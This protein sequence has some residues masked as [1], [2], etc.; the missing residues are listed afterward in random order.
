MDNEQII[1]ILLLLFHI[2][3]I[4]VEL[5][6][7]SSS[8]IEA[9]F[10]IKY[11]LLRGIAIVSFGAFY[12]LLIQIKGTSIK[13]PDGTVGIMVLLFNNK[14]LHLNEVSIT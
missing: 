7:I 3:F 14:Y 1:I 8:S 10:F 9:I 12:S 5:F 6:D 13:E 2:I 4:L 11:I